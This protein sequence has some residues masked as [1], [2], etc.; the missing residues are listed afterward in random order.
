VAISGAAPGAFFPLAWTMLFNLASLKE[1][2]EGQAK[3]GGKEA[4]S[5]IATTP[6]V[7]P[8]GLLF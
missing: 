2:N 6:A 4:Q 7:V 8:W 3:R 1:R 5:Y